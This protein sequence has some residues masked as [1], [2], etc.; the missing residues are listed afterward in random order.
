MLGSTPPPA[1]PPTP[2]ARWNDLDFVS[3]AAAYTHRHVFYGGEAFPIWHRGYPGDHQLASHIG[4]TDVEQ[5]A[6]ADPA[7]LETN[8]AARPARP[9]KAGPNRSM[10]C[11]QEYV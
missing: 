5:G 10:Q 9:C 2:E 4:Q 3:A 6:R 7:H 8:A 11:N 1:R